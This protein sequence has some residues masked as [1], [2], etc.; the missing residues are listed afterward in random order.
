MESGGDLWLLLILSGIW[1]VP[2]HLPRGSKNSPLARNDSVTNEL[3]LW[4]PLRDRS[5]TFCSLESPPRATATPRVVSQPLSGGN[6]VQPHLILIWFVSGPH[7]TAGSL[8]PV[9]SALGRPGRGSLQFSA[10]VQ[11]GFQGYRGRPCLEKK[12]ISI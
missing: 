11:S 12:K 3:S 5:R 10:G 9:I 6:R 4:P 1:F 7:N 2:G 8:A